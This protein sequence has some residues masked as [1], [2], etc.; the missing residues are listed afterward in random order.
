MYLPP[1]LQHPRSPISGRHRSY[2]SYL[3][4]RAAAALGHWSLVFD[5]CA[6][7]AEPS[8]RP[9]EMPI[10]QAASAAVAWIFELRRR[11]RIGGTASPRSTAKGQIHVL[12]PRHPNDAIAAS[13]SAQPGI[14]NCRSRRGQRSFDSIRWLWLTAAVWILAQPLNVRFPDHGRGAILVDAPRKA[15]KKP[16]RSRKSRQTVNSEV[17]RIVMAG[18]PSS[19]RS[20][21]L[22]LGR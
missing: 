13:L 9:S 2:I 1:L 12:K 21:G 20:A 11:Q 3:A 18:R 7:P 22:E 14:Y 6:M 10:G 16:E 19:T 5:S 8:L 15:S 4:G 17:P